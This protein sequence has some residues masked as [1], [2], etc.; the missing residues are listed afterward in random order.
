MKLRIAKRKMLSKWTW[1]VLNLVIYA[2]A[3][4]KTD[5]IKAFIELTEF[6]YEDACSNTAEAEWAFV[7]TP[8][9]ETLLTWEKNLISYAAF[10]N[11]QKHEVVDNVSKDDTN[12]PV[13][14]YKYDIVAKAGDALLTDKD[15]ETL[16]HFTGTVE[17]LKLSKSGGGVLSNYTRGDVEHSL[18]RNQ[19]VENKHS[20]WTAWHQELN[21]LVTNFS[22]VLLLTHKAI[23]ANGAKDS[24]EYWE[25]LSGY[26][27]GYSKIIYEWEKISNLHK[28]LVK[29]VSTNLS[30]KYK[31]A[32][33]ETVPA[34]LLGSLQGNDW[35]TISV[36]AVPYPDI[37][38]NIKK[39][40]WKKKLIGKSLYKAASAMSLKIFNQ[41]PQ[42][43]FWDKSHF[44]QQCPS[45]L[46]NFCE[47]GIM[48]V[49]TCF[50]PTISNFLSAHKNIG[51]I[52]FNQMSAETI[53]VL[54]TANRYSALEEAVSE[55]FG[56]L[57]TSPAWLKYIHVMDESTD[58]DQDSIVTLMITALST[59]P[60]LAYYISADMWRINAIETNITN[61]VDLI[62]S[63]WKYRQEYEGIISNGTEVP[64][65]LSDEYITS[66]K[67]YLSKITGII[68]AFQFY[69]HLMETTEIRYDSIL[70][71][72]IKADFIKMIQQRGDPNWM[73]SVDKFLDLVEIS[74]DSLISFFSPLEDF[75]DELEGNY[76]Y[77]T[78]ANGET[79]L[80]E[81]EKKIL[82]EV[83]KPITTTVAPIT[84][85]FIIAK[86][87]TDRQK[88]AINITLVNKQKGEGGDVRTIVSTN[89]SLES[90]SSIHVP[91]KKLDSPSVLNLQASTTVPFDESLD[92][93]LNTEQ[94]K[95]PRIDTS[96]AVWA[97]GAVLLAII[98]ICAVAIFG[99]QRC[100]KT[101]KNRRYV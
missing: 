43:D 90:E 39:N 94:E 100:R 81:L 56:I 53:A 17:L 20:L 30:H 79:E 88:S 3:S 29:F 15:Y 26:N 50:E 24:M 68:L 1:I 38:Y 77:D 45:K 65:F 2:S 10:K 4:L 5:A 54:N 11:V 13:L 95:K 46:I 87:S 31:I 67:P 42:A 37:T 76:N 74:S 44:N 93:N 86:E 99:R 19:N 14:Q 84:T 96:K 70:E 57:A 16:V 28:K 71:K 8:S 7:N 12:D 55:L 9:N 83:N 80:E 78:V 6:E 51:K 47:E 69:E 62:S 35:T 72:R 97:V 33:N 59:L 73:R 101:P 92:I 32:I 85:N 75:I 23:E 25:L 82:S 40:L 64:T 34:Y 22:T 18:S 49:S 27:N 41:V 21:P 66:N 60:R 36:D 58:S 52:V 89:K 63:W 61:P 98:I 91:V 48:R